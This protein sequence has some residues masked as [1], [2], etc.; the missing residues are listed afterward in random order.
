MKIII[1]VKQIAHTFSRTGMNPDCHYLVAEDTLYRV[2]P[3]DEVAVEMALKAR[4]AAGKG[5]VLLLT[6]GPLIAEGELRRCLAMG[7]DRLFHVD[8]EGRMDPW[9]KSQVLAGCIRDMD[10]DLVLC[11]KES[12]DRRNGQ[13]GAFLAHHLGL[14]FVSAITDLKVPKGGNTATVQRS[15]GRGVREIIECRLPAVLSVDL[16]AIE[17][18][19]PSYRDKQAASHRPVEPLGPVKVTPVPK[20]VCQRVFPP[21]PRPKPVPAPKSDL[22][23]F[24]RIRWLL[25]GSRVE[26]K[27]AMLTG[28]PASQVEGIIAFLKEQHFLQSD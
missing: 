21:R 14:P 27:G 20:V 26:K 8:A 22:R 2:N 17:P 15:A 5:E 1:C 9:S 11:G 25:A 18:R 6:L 12:L 4:E 10:A 24:D 7:A 16:G 23:A 13:T 19:V 28:D 3:Y